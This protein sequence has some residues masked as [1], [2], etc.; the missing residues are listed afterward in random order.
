MSLVR[1]KESQVTAATVF[2]CTY[3]WRAEISADEFARGTGSLSWWAW[4]SCRWAKFHATHLPRRSS[5]V[6]VAVKSINTVLKAVYNVNSVSGWFTLPRR[7]H[8]S[9]I[10]N[11]SEKWQ[12]QTYSFCELGV[13]HKVV[14]ML[15]GPSQLQFT[16]NDGNH[17]CCTAGALCKMKMAKRWRE[18]KRNR[19]QCVCVVIGLNID[20]MTC[21]KVQT[22]RRRTMR[23]E[24]TA[25]PLPQ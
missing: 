12:L 18:W 3:R 6:E 4:C 13:H 19:C 2:Y 8:L 25:M 11:V 1:I 5:A 20:A 7:Q 23:P 16:G 9:D 21:R 15:L 22:T 14:H 17:E 10:K 24:K